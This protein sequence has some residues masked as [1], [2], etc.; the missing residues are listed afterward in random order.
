MTEPSIDEAAAAEKEAI[1]AQAPFWR[2]ALCAS[3]QAAV[4]LVNRPPAQV[5]GQ[6]VSS[7]RDNGQTDTFYFL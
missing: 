6:A 3:P 7:V 5:A 1:S 2:Y 4:D